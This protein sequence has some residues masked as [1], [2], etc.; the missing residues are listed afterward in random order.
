MKRRPAASRGFFRDLWAS[1]WNPARDPA[2]TIKKQ[3]WLSEGKTR[4]EV[5]P[6]AAITSDGRSRR[7]HEFVK[8]WDSVNYKWKYWFFK[9]L[10]LCVERFVAKYHNPRGGW[11]NLRRFPWNDHAV[12]FDK[13]Y[14]RA[15]D[16]FLLEYFRAGVDSKFRNTSPEEFLKAERKGTTYRMLMA[17]KRAYLHYILTDPVYREFHAC[18]MLRLHVESNRAYN[19]TVTKTPRTPSGL[20]APRR[21]RQHLFHTSTS[22]VDVHYMHLY[23]RVA[24]GQ[25]VPRCSC[26]PV[27]GDAE[28][29]ARVHAAYDARL[30]KTLDEAQSVVRAAAKAGLEAGVIL[31]QAQAEAVSRAV[32]AES[33]RLAG[34][35]VRAS[36]DAAPPGLGVGAGRKPYPEAS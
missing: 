2:R 3:R 36:T 21:V 17:S 14:D 15:V 34:E 19:K 7:A 25:F 20:A 22:A 24:N 28:V 33:L 1:L 5:I 10:L 13:A 30:P 29:N 16:D 26:H 27:P 18:L 11:R 6:A 8:R 12:L 32:F 9:P 35:R 31:S 4:N 23:G